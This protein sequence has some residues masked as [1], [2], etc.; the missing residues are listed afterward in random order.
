MV[1]RYF[2]KVI[3]E[4]QGYAAYEIHSRTSINDI[5]FLVKKI[6]ALGYYHSCYILSYNH[7]AFT[8]IN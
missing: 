5:V 4:K 7:I 3:S 2:V 6:D 8:V 1:I